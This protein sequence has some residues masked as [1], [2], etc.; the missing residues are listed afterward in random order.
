M[1]NVAANATVRPDI[2]ISVGL[3]PE[4]IR[5][6]PSCGR[7]VGSGAIVTLPAAGHQIE[8]PSHLAAHD[9]R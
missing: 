9:G 2:K 3:N 5:Q 4:S 6:A 1:K 8:D 7:M